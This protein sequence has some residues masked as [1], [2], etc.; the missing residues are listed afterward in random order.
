MDEFI[1]VVEDLEEGEGVVLL[2]EVFVLFVCEVM[3]EFVE[4]VVLD[5]DVLKICKGMVVLLCGCDVL[6]NCE[7]VYVS[8]VSVL[9]VIGMIEKGC[10]QFSWVFYFQKFVV[11]LDEICSVIR[12]VK[13]S[14]VRV[15][16]N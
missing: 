6:F 2:V 7:I 9:V 8:Y 10:F 4:V 15:L 14:L 3:D 11:F 16:D 12:M 13:I 1:Q 5:D